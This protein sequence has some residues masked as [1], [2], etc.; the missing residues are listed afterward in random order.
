M[1][2]SRLACHFS[3]HIQR[4]INPKRLHSYVRRRID[5][6]GPTSGRS[7]LVILFATRL[8]SMTQS[9]SGAATRREWGYVL[10]FFSVFGK[11]RNN[12]LSAPPKCALIYFR[13]CRASLATATGFSSALSS[14]CSINL[15]IRKGVYGVGRR[16]EW[17]PGG[18]RLFKSII[19]SGNR[20]T[21][22]VK[23]RVTVRAR[24]QFWGVAYW[25][26]G[27]FAPPDRWP[28]QTK[29]VR[30]FDLSREVGKESVLLLASRNLSTLTKTPGSEK[31]STPTPIIS[32][33]G[34][35]SLLR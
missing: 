20:R 33:N 23:M 3:R 30:N 25:V 16:D 31:C 24:L 1:S 14:P 11:R 12:A 15:E 29:L 2:A 22:Y 18:R 28:G 32:W 5:L 26:R 17:R 21:G 19:L 27:T 4:L 35:N 34:F 13:Y 9:G 8:R 7:N 10:C 6:P